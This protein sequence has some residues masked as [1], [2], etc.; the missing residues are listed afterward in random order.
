MSAREPLI[1][2][3]PAGADYGGAS[4]TA[5]RHHYDRGNDFFALWLDR[6]LTYSCA[7]WA[8][9]DETLEAAQERKLDQLILAAGAR[10]AERVLDVGCG[11]G[12]MLRRLVEHHGVGRAVGLTL[13]PAQ[14][15]HAAARSDARVEVRVENW[16][17]HV[18]AAPYDAIVSIGA[19]EHFA[20]W[21]MTRSQRLDAYRAFFRSCH[22]WLPRR[23][24]LA[25]QTIA[26]GSDVRLDRTMLREVR[27]VIERI[28]PE[29]ELPWVSEIFQASER[30][31]EPVWVRNDPDH[32]T[33]TCDAWAERLQARRSEAVLAAG[34]ETVRDY[35]R[36]LRSAAEG[37]RR[38]HFGLMRIAFERV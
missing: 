22:E 29:S 36:Y 13:S 19:F 35:E 17:D 31:F 7:L 10:G 23:G 12:G 2:D 15:E 1:P 11:W 20:D 32:Y 8:G 26:K 18:P 28:F 30:R 5:I 6:S 21:G 24:R 38:R 4:A 3:A 33:R 25:L 37:F 9:D 14:A 27:F 16:A 34:E